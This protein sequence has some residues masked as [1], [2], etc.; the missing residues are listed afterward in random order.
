[1]YVD[2][3]HSDCFSWFLCV[4]CWTGC[5]VVNA[6]VVCV[7]SILGFHYQTASLL[8]CYC[9]FTF[10]LRLDRNR[11]T[12]IVFGAPSFS[13]RSQNCSGCF[14]RPTTCYNKHAQ[15]A[16]AWRKEIHFIVRQLAGTLSKSLKGNPN[17]WVPA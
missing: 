11:C 16:K 7:F 12:Y 14:L 17:A 10:F 5:N 15:V 8:A 9:P 2:A 13:F 1:M 6:V 3:K 4:S